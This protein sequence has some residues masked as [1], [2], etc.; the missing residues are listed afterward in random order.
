[1]RGHLFFKLGLFFTSIGWNVYS[2]LEEMNSLTLYRMRVPELLEQQ[3]SIEEE[4]LELE[5]KVRSFRSYKHFVHLLENTKEYY[6]PTSDQIFN[7]DTKC[8]LPNTTTDPKI[9]N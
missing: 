6:I 4:V 9:L 8:P 1:M 2:Y 5:Y 3:Q 7:I